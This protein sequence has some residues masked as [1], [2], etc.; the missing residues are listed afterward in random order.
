MSVPPGGLAALTGIAGSGRTA[1][2]LTLGGRM[3]PSGGEAVV[4]GHELPREMRAVQRIAGLGVVAGVTDLEPALTVREHVSEALDLREGLF[5]RW[6]HRARRVQEAL[7]RVGLDVPP[8]TRA[9]DLAPDE[10]CLL[11]AAL[12]LVGEP[13]LLLLDDV[14]EG[15]PHDRQRALWERLAALAGDVTVLATCHD[16]APAEGLAR[17]VALPDPHAVEAVR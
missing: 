11:G 6:R 1:L 3:R 5:G 15:L 16:P 7:D 9:D 8:R 4:G 14:D 10:A 17:I 2:L 12:A 13:R